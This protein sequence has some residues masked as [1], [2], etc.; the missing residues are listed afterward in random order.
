MKIGFLILAGIIT[1]V[2]NAQIL[3]PALFVETDVKASAGKNAPFYSVSNKHGVFSDEKNTLLLRSG[4]TAGID[5][6]KKISLSYGLDA[7]YRYGSESGIWLQQGYA[8]VK[9]HFLIIQGGIVEEAFGNQDDQLSS[10]AY[11]FS[12]NARPMPKIALYTNDYVIVPYTKNLLEIKGYFAH[13]WFGEKDQYVKNAWL[14]Q[15]Y[16]YI[17]IGEKRFPW[18]V[19]LGIHH[20]AVWGGTSPVYGSLRADWEAFRSVFFARMKGD[21]GPDNEQENAVGNH[22]ASYSLGIDYTMKRHKLKF[23][24]QT[25]LDDKNGRVGVDWKN[26]GD[27]LWG[28]VIQKRDDSNGLRKVGLEFFNSTSQSGDPNFSGGDNYFNN[29]LY[30]SGWTYRDM[31]I[32]T[33]LITSPVFTNRTPEMQDYLENNSLRALTAGIIYEFDEKQVSIRLT[34]ARNFGTIALP[35]EQPRDQLYS[36]IGYNY[37]S[38]RYKD[39]MF[40]WEGAFDTG[41]HFG[42]NIGLLFRMRKTF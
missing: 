27:G 14:H 25:M 37:Y 3:R 7:I 31:T 19:N 2:S 35:Y 39:L 20:T 34:Y 29:Y 15:K 18:S 23:Y 5:T 42:N 36:L 26:K 17:R 16:F 8:H 11:L 13:G 41:S 28:I 24:W 30:R 10:G 38:R 22:L 6:S 12:E 32:G 40:S 21:Q 1:L 33:P 9:I 4:I